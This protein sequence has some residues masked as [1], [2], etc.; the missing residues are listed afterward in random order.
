MENFNKI[1]RNIVVQLETVTYNGDLSDIGNE[2]GIVIGKYIEKD[3]MGCELDD[4][5]HGIKHGISLV[6]GT[7]DKGKKL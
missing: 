2:I 5:I 3:K 7:H 6:D 1:I 4:F